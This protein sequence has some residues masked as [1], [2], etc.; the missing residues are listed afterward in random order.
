MNATDIRQFLIEAI[1]DLPWPPRR[2]AAAMALAT[3]L[4]A[5]AGY[6][7]PRLWREAP[8]VYLAMGD[9]GAPAPNRA[10]KAEREA[11][12]APAPGG[13]A[14]A[15]GQR[16]PQT[17]V[18]ALAA[19]PA[20]APSPDGAPAAAPAMTPPAAPAMT[21]DGAPDSVPRQTAEKASPPAADGGATAST[22]T[23]VSV[24]AS[25]QTLAAAGS[26]AGQRTPEQGTPAQ[27]T[28]GQG[29]QDQG[30][31]GQGPA[32]QDGLRQEAMRRDPTSDDPPSPPADPAEIA[33]A[34]APA[35]GRVP[36]PED[37]H[38]LK[39]IARLLHNH[40]IAAAR[41]VLPRLQGETARKLGY[42]SYLIN[43]KSDASASEIAAF[44]EA[45][46]L[47]PGRD[48]L[49]ERAER[50]LILQGAEWRE[51]IGY[52][53]G[54][55]PKSGPGKAALG[56]ALFAKGEK[57]RGLRL[58]REAWRQRPLDDDV[59]AKLFERFGE[60]LTEADHK[61]RADFLS[62]KGK[63]SKLAAVS[64]FQ[65][66][67]GG[68]AGKKESGNFA[69][70]LLAARS[71]AR[72]LARIQELRKQDKR[73]EAWALLRAAPRDAGGDPADW[74]PER[75]LQAREALNRGFPKIAYAIVLGHG[76]LDGEM[77]AEAGFMAGWIAL[78][79]LNDP[80]T[81]SQHLAAAAQA[82][83]LPKDQAR[84][85][86]W[87]A[88]SELAMAKK[89]EAYGHFAEAARRQHTFYGQLARTALGGGAPVV[90]LRPPARPTAEDM[91]SFLSMDVVE[92]ALIAQ[93]AG[94]ESFTPLF[95]NDIARRADS[96]GLLTL[97]AE[98]GQRAAPQHVNVRFAKVALNRG[99]PLEQY[100]YPAA[101][102]QFRPLIDGGR[103]DL[104]LL[105]ALTRQESEFNT[106][107]V[108][109]ANARGLMQL[110]PGTA[111]QMCRAYGVK[112]E[113]SKLT[114]DPAY[115]VSLGSAYLYKVLDDYGGSYV[116]AL[117]SYN[118]GPGRVREWIALFG[119]PR[120]PKVDPLDWVERIPFT[121]TREYVQKILESIQLYR[122]RL[123]GGQGSLRLVE[124][125]YRGR[126]TGA[127]P[128]P[129]GGSGP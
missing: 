40:N 118:A 16:E 120:D 102:P 92:A 103:L 59:E 78:R 1:D 30:T 108:S 29:T 38:A 53:Q 79:F 57:E 42:W 116:M 36:G 75:R 109:V 65:Q 3:V 113:A 27:G 26:P 41:A 104:A 58:L 112:Y 74:W 44:R 67:P 82:G 34:L 122:A 72:L 128:A 115:N 101:L 17:P 84:A 90:S 97:V 43:A 88:R 19:P 15:N 47:W 25:E 87:L 33:A 93:K 24:S 51:T 70:Q 46:P 91:R 127:T 123:G 55:Q 45:N 73:Q 22:G 80:R 94:L 21:A 4:G 125:L 60:V 117:A 85:L 98:F 52:F 107:I 49:D 13:A 126:P 2:L 61:H 12:G 54:R 119:D 5:V 23:V 68:A 35:L 129:V 89:A 31:P 28:S 66:K 121:E 37:T 86:Y 39:E 81:A 96:A 63:R 50:A 48:T 105:H 14:V 69:M 11:I 124:D 76:P 32:R 95:Y 6:T 77:Q 99:F 10:A 111:Q 56:S 18:A 7:W 114:G 100:A 62:F 64:R 83:G 71:P 110:L 20:P 106:R 8:A 9:E